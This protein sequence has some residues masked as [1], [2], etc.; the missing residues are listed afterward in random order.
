MFS[1]A[2][3]DTVVNFHDFLCLFN[4]PF[5]FR[6]HLSELGFLPGGVAHRTHDFTCEEAKL[7]MILPDRLSEL[8]PL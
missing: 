1:P 4:V 2:G 6:Q 5:D 7:L 8:L 3:Y